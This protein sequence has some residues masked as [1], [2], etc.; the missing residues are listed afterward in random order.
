MRK[1]SPFLLA[2]TGSLFVAVVGLSHA[3]LKHPPYAPTVNAEQQSDSGLKPHQADDA[4]HR[5]ADNAPPSVPAIGGEGGCGECKPKTEHGEDEGTEFWPPLYGYRLKVTDTFVAAFTAL[6]FFA[7][8]ALWLSTRNL[9]RGADKTA[10]RQ[11]RAYLVPGGG[12]IEQIPGGFRM[13]IAL[14]NTGQTPAF[15]VRAMS[16]SFGG[17]YPLEGEHA[18]APPRDDYSSII[19]SGGEFHCLRRIFSD[20]PGEI[21]SNVQAGEMGLW[22]QGWVTYED[23][24]GKPHH[25]K[26][27]SVFGGPLV[28]S[29]DLLL[30]PDREGNEAD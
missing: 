9:V 20:S 16:E 3:L 30:H 23:C 24:F 8:L 12:E 28:S 15:K 7:T 14:R 22:I 10:E 19:G 2:I 18:H 21:L 29:G 1:T 6:L 4:K 25:T 27:R 17:S 5:S 26:F 11:L 13:T